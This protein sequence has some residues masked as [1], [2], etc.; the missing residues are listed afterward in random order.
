MTDVVVAGTSKP[1]SRS[2]GDSLPAAIVSLLDGSSLGTKIGV[3]FQLFT[4]DDDG[5]VRVALLSVGELVA[6]SPTDL[7]LAL[8]PKSASTGN[9]IR[10]ARATLALAQGGDAHYIRVRVRPLMGARG[11][12]SALAYF[13]ASVDD[14]RLHH[15]AYARLA[16]WIT[17]EL[18]KPERELARW[19]ETIATLR[20]APSQVVANSGC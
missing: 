4:V 15:V 6:V 11:G 18:A 5:W 14:V 13:Q 19:R 20:T 10:T 2:L 8:W 12:K 16:S 7:Q 3:T 1:P 9:L 17:F